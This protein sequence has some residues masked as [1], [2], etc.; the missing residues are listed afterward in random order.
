MAVTFALVSSSLN[1]LKYKMTSAAAESGNLDAAGAATPDLLTDAKN[2][3]PLKTLLGTVVAD[4]AACRALFERADLEIGILPC[5]ADAL[6]SIAFAA[7]ANKVRLTL[8]AA[9]I[10]ADGSYLVVKYIH[11]YIQ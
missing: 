3:S 11:T 4:A 6:W 5:D 7:N 1:L 9:A 8:A 2:G 10:D